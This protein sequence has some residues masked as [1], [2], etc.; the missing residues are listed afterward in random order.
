MNT[1]TPKRP[2]RLARKTIYE[3]EWIKLHTDNVEFPD[4]RIIENL[5]V[6]D[7]PQEAVGVI[8]V[9]DK[10]EVLLEYA[11]RYHTN[12]DGWEVPAGGIDKG[13]NIIEA[14]KREVLEETGYET[15]Q[16]KLIYTY[17][18][19]NGSSN[20]VFHIVSCAI[21]SSEQASFDKNEVREVKWFTEKKIKEMIKNNDI[22]DGY[23][24]SALLLHF[25]K[26]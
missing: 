10:E 26:D 12:E 3:S 22:K 1:T 24:L 17:N 4:G 8:V 5:H 16:H 7:Y 20:Q 19:S 18:P 14:S 21:T 15:T 11:Y 2:K 6:L 23:T 9:N 13:E 25:L